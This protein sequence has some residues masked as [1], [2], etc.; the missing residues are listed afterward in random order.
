M[1]PMRK[2]SRRAVIGGTLLAIG[3]VLTLLPVI[4]KSSPPSAFAAAKAVYIPSNW[5][6]TGEVPWAQNRTKESANF[7]LLWGEKS[8]TDPKRASGDVPLRPG[9][10]PLPARER[11]TRSTSTR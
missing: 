1:A 9:Q 6:A 10:H 7:I 3:L 11:S 8:G 2:R 5:A 4:F